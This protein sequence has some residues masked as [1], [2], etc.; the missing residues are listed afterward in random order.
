MSVL[1]KIAVMRS[2][3]CPSRSG[4]GAGTRGQQ[5]GRFRVVGGL[6]GE[7]RQ[8]RRERDGHIPVIELRHDGESVAV[9]GANG[10]VDV[11]AGAAQEGPMTPDA[12]RALGS[13]DLEKAH[14]LTRFR[15]MSFTSVPMGEI[16]AEPE[17]PEA[18]Q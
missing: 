11:S 3:S 12:V 4:G 6:I 1:A 13:V 2:S 8:A 14:Q 10:A 18:M 16:R 5:H 9:G 15:K 17:R 7:L